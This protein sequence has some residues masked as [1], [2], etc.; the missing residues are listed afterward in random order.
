M[1]KLQH[2][3][4]AQNTMN[5]TA[6]KT[7]LRTLGRIL[8]SESKLELELNDY[9]NIARTNGQKIEIN[10]DNPS[11]PNATRKMICNK[12]KLYHE[13]GHVNFTRHPKV[14]AAIYSNLP[15][16]IA[17]N[18]MAVSNIIEDGRI[19]FLMKSNFPGT[20]PYF[21]YLMS[22]FPAMPGDMV[23]ELIHYVRTRKFTTIDATNFYAP[24][25]ARIDAAI[26][27]RSN[28]KTVWQLAA[29][30]VTALPFPAKMQAPCYS[31]PQPQPQDSPDSDGQPQ[32][33]PDSDG[34]PQDSP[35]SDG[36]PQD[37]PDS[38]DS[39]EIIGEQTRNKIAKQLETEIENDLTIMAGGAYQIKRASGQQPLLP[40]E[41][42]EAT[43]LAT[44][45]RQ[46]TTEATRQ[47]YNPSRTRGRVDTRRI[48]NAVTGGD[49]LQKR[50][51]GKDR[52]P[53]VCLLVDV[54][55]SMAQPVVTPKRGRPYC[56][57][58]ADIAFSA[59][60][61]LRAA[62]YDAKLFCTA[63]AFGHSVRELK[64]H[65]GDIPTNNADLHCKD[66]DTQLA[67]GLD[68]VTALMSTRDEPRKLCIIIT[69]G[70]SNYIPASTIEN[71]KRNGIFTVGIGINNPKDN[72]AT[73]HTVCDMVIPYNGESISN[74]LS[75][76]VQR[77]VQ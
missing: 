10:P 26:W 15:Y 62:I 72:L 29:D 64:N 31:Q 49:L 68:A 1:A 63:L 36:Q 8:S 40:N 19:E 13:L 43:R 21:S 35:D 77:F 54:S 75:S 7:R 51:N 25:I 52:R 55:G 5:N 46:V 59:S 3:Q 65:A 69:D 28:S 4:G 66:Y 60:R 74:D 23:S 39:P 45:L 50:A 12:A 22:Y 33:S 16:G 47:T 34:Q 76:L 44:I 71:L 73:L 14:R 70:E 18:F 42:A 2:K 20:R 41:H 27:K 17:D 37:S 9:C 48:T 38:P 56:E 30:M 67:P 53:A 61:I 58:R 11:E 57:T 24:F 32:D 6:L